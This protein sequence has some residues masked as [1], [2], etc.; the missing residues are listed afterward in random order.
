MAYFVCP[1][2]LCSH[3]IVYLAAATAAAT[4]AGSAVVGGVRENVLL[5]FVRQLGFHKYGRAVRFLSYDTTDFNYYDSFTCMWIDGVGSYFKELCGRDFLNPLQMEQQCGEHKGMW[6]CYTTWLL[7][8][9]YSEMKRAMQCHNHAAIRALSPGCYHIL[10]ASNHFNVGGV[11]V[12]LCG[13]LL[14]IVV[15]H[16]VVHSQSN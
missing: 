7:M 15:A 11:S 13:L 14:P 12:C 8:L 9:H 2:M 1:I 3:L 6:D 10:M 16:C 4:A 5:G